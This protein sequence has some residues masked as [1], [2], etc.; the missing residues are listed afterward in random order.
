MCSSDLVPRTR[1]F[2]SDLVGLSFPNNNFPWLSYTE[3]NN[4]CLPAGE[5]L[6]LAQALIPSAGPWAGQL[7]RPPPTLHAHAPACWSPVFHLHYR[8]S[9]S[10]CPAIADHLW[11][12]Q[13]SDL[14][15]CPVGWTTSSSAGSEFQPWGGPLPSCSF[16]GYP[17][18]SLRVQYRVSFYLTV[19]RLSECN[20]F[21]YQTSSV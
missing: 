4:L 8:G 11:P 21:L 7:S 5:G 15:R 17:L 19:T 14:L 1:Q 18:S 9:L 16:L 10:A 6:L 3:N 13:T 12:G 2:L 20:N